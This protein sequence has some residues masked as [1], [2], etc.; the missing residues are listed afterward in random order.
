MKSNYKFFIASLL[1]ISIATTFISPA[2]AGEKGYRYWGYFQSQTGTKPWVSSMTGPTTN[3]ADKS[4]EGWVFTF[5][6]DTVDAKEPRA[7]PNFA[8]LCGKIKPVANKKRVGVVVEYGRAALRPQGETPP[9]NIYSCV[10]IQKN[11]TGFDVVGEAVKIR[12][13][14]SGLICAFNGY[15]AKECGAEVATPASFILKK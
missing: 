13:S 11:A 5:S 15:P 3:V 12:A 10:V 9:A 6:S 1:L 7:L 4:V 14:A 2:S 8:R